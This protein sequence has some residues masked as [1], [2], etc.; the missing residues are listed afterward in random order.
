MF[1]FFAK[2][3]N[4]Y[5]DYASAT[6]TRK[7]AL[8]EMEKFS[9]VFANPGSIHKDGVSAKRTLDGLR[10]RVAQSISSRADEIVFVGTST[11]SDNL[12][13][14]GVVMAWREKNENKIPH[15]ITTTIEHNAVS[16]IFKQLEKEGLAE[17]SFVSVLSD[18]Q[19]NLKE[20]KTLLKE[21]TI[22]FSFIHG[23]NEIGTIQNVE[24]IVK[25]IRHFK[26]HT[27]GDARNLYPLIH[28]DASQS[29]PYTDIQM[30]KM[31]VDLMSLNSSKVYGPKGV[32]LLYVKK[33]T[34]IQ[35]IIFGGGQELGLR[36]GT[37]DIAGIAGFAKA[38]ELAKEEREKESLRLKNLQDFFFKEID[39]NFSR[40]V[41]VN[42]S[43]EER[44]PNNINITVFNFESELLVL[45]LDAK[46]FS[47]SSK[48]ACNESGDE[49]SSIMQAINPHEDARIGGVRITFGKE[50]TKKDLEL[51]LRSL[52]ETIEKYK[53]FPKQT[54]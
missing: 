19:I 21:N 34:P 11:E 35:S 3:K 31:G 10:K 42:G 53:N 47:V 12:A 7:E 37:Q 8:K 33:G 45:E 1:K 17:I 24:E 32:A 28:T 5:L 51:F 40:L 13:V 9:G 22:L 18:G 27:L 44:L 23:N 49:E 52:K 6:P 25:L 15:I 29:F 50:T 2:K 39:N 14:R 54:V 20:L 36:P 48:S 26:K 38:L 46:G 41:R 43:R 16:S 4:I 30:N